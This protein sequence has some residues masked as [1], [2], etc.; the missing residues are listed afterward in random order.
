MSKPNRLSRVVTSIEKKLP[1]ALQKKAL[2][3][4]LGRTVKLVGTAG[5][6][7]LELTPERS[8]FRIRNRG[9]VQNHIK[10]VHAAAMALVAET[11]TGMVLGMSVPDDK[12]P[13]LKSMHVDYKKR[14]SGDLTATASLTPEQIEKIKTLDKGDV[15]IR[16]V[17][18]DSEN[19]EPIEATMV[20]AWTPKRR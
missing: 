20:W 15:D 13:V 9:K 1:P 16:V 7:C 12:I 3:F 2:S 10:G 11:A 5:V 6:E 8:A 19:K 17:C 4:A 14:C 18:T